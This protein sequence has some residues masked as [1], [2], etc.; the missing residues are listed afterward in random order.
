MGNRFFTLMAYAR[1]MIRSSSKDASPAS[2]VLRFGVAA[3]LSAAA[4]R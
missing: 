2:G 1:P 4:I 3:T